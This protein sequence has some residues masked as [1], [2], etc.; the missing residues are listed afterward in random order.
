MPEF[1]IKKLNNLQFGCVPANFFLRLHRGQ[2]Y[3]C[4]ACEEPTM[5]SYSKQIDG[6]TYCFK[7]FTRIK[8]CRHSED[9]YRFETKEFARWNREFPSTGIN[10]LGS[11]KNGDVYSKLEL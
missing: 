6:R 4:Y 7:C 5:A 2:A 8:M 10:L 9:Y 1:G 11:S 3:L